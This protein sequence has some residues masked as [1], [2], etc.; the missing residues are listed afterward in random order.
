MTRPPVP[1]FRLPRA[2]SPGRGWAAAS[3][4]L[5]T[6]LLWLVIWAHGRGGDQTAPSDA[7]GWMGRLPGGGGGGSVAVLLDEP[8]PQAPARARVPQVPPPPTPVPEPQVPPP[9]PQPVPAESATVAAEVASD[10]RSRDA[11]QN[12]GPGESGAGGGRG[13]GQGPGQG[14]GIGSD[15][16]P[17]VGGDEGTVFPPKP[18][19]AIL[20][21]IPYPNSLK[22]QTVM[23]RFWIDAS[24]RVTKLA[25]ETPVKDGGYRSKLLAALYEYT[26]EPART[27]GGRKVDGQLVIPITLGG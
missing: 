27:R 20:P 13:G 6:G 23:V 17:G 12:A 3:I 15:S 25:L 5:H 8:V 22:G 10:T 7:P 18:R 2:K 9:E 24:G 11:V 1:T 4:A 19:Y 16:G 26:F 21:P 14:T